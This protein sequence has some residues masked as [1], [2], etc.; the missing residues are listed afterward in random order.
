MH[1][2]LGTAFWYSVADTCINAICSFVQLELVS[3]PLLPFCEV[4]LSLVGSHHHFL[5]LC[6]SHNSDC[7]FLQFETFQCD[8]GVHYFWSIYFLIYLYHFA[9]FLFVAQ[10]WME[11]PQGVDFL[12]DCGPDLNEEPPRDRI[13]GPNLYKYRSPPKIS[14]H[15]QKNWRNGSWMWGLSLI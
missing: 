6:Y 12:K 11:S 10:I 8:D 1:A 7:V 2:P 13:F 14:N 5:F 9:L 15:K 3:T 4:S